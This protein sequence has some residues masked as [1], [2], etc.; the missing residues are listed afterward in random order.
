MLNRIKTK[1][2]T[3]IFPT[4]VRDEIVSYEVIEV[5]VDTESLVSGNLVAT[6]DSIEY[7]DSL[8]GE[9]FTAEVRNNLKF[10]SQVKDG[11]V[12]F[13]FEL[14]EQEKR[15]FET[16]PTKLTMIESSAILNATD[17][18]SVSSFPS[19]TFLLNKKG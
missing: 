13:D 1:Q 11:K 8:N 3:L 7:A 18:A 4:M 2:G 17:Y 19:L 15:W 14:A 9:T 6:I 5:E 12:D 16:S 10:T